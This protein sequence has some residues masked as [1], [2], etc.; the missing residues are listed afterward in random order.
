ME[1]VDK[2]LNSNKNPLVGGKRADIDSVH[3]D[4]WSNYNSRLYKTQETENLYENS[5][6]Q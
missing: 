6:K 5:A 2:I 3:L 4:I 1:S